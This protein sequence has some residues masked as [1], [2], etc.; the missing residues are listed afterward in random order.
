MSFN[1]GKPQLFLK[2]KHQCN[3][4]NVNP[5]DPH[6]TAVSTRSRSSEKER[7]GG[8]MKR[9]KHVDAVGS[10]VTSAVREHRENS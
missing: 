5:C 1:N 9:L 6:R 7:Y 8:R 2:V 4:A 10:L 3:Q